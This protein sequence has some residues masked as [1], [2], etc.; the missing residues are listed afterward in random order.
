MSWAT[1]FYTPEFA[2]LFLDA[3]PP[4]EQDIGFIKSIGALQSGARIFDQ[5][6]GNGRL[7][8][9]LDAAGFSVIGV[10][11]IESYIQ[12]AKEKHPTADF[13][14]ED[15]CYFTTTKPCDIALNWWTS[16]GYGDT[17]ED[18]K[19]LSLIHI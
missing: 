11:I 19:N 3:S 18:D 8:A 6:C 9:S 16:F 2:E 15:A 10:D 4:T 12:T 5:C 14:T 17:P 13:F 1:D 7:S